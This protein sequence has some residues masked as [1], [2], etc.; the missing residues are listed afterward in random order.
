MP[1]NVRAVWVGNDSVRLRWTRPLRPNGAVLGYRLYF[2]ANDNFTDVVTV[3]VADT[4]ATQRRRSLEHTIDGLG[5]DRVA[6][7][8]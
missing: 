3:R 5:E 4:G 1:L 2:M 6:K 7:L 8:K